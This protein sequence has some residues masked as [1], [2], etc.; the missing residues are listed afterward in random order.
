M[1]AGDAF[2]LPDAFGVHLNIILAVLEDGSLIVCHFTTRRRYSD[3]TCII[4]PGEHPFVIV[5]TV[6]KYDQA[7]Q[8]PAGSGVA[9][10][11]SLM[12]RCDPLSAELFK[13]VFQGALDSPQTPDK[14]KN[15]LRPPAQAE[16]TKAT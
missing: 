4:H 5:E 11:E 12:K 1:N 7:H 15:I 13:R 6:V 3:T 8:C 16:P 14:I 2:L 9:A 10:F